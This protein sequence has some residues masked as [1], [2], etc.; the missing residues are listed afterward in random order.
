MPEESSQVNPTGPSKS[1]RWGRSSW[2]IL[3]IFLFV[4]LLIIIVWQPLVKDYFSYFNPAYPWWMQIDWLLIAI[5]AFLSVGV[6]Y[7]ADLREDWMIIIVALA[8]GFV[9]ETWGTRS[10]LWSYYT[11]EMPPLWIVP[12]WPIAALTIKRVVDLIYL[13][14][15][16]GNNPFYTLAYWCVMILFLSIMAIFLLNAQFNIIN[17][18]AFGICL[19]FIIIPQDRIYSLLTFVAGSVLGIFLEYWG[20]SREC[21]TYYNHAIPPLFAVLA[22]GLASIAFW[23]CLRLGGWMISK[24][25]QNLKPSKYSAS[26]EG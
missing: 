10:G 4:I 12:A 22:H 26:I 6:T 5:F 9:I 3:T 13:R 24:W 21:W 17:W 15:R 14:K 25:K 16:P 7:N 19:V 1:P 23:H 20:T 2:I 8:G 18:L 11:G